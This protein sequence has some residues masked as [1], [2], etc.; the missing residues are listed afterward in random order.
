MKERRGRLRSEQEEIVALLKQRKFSGLLCSDAERITLKSEITIFHFPGH[1]NCLWGCN[2]RYAPDWPGFEQR[3]RPGEKCNA[4][5][6][7]LFCSCCCIFE[8]SLPYLIDR[9]AQIEAH[10][11][12][13]DESDFISTLKAEK[14]LID[15]LVIAWDDDA[16]IQRAFA[17]QQKNSPLFP[18]DLSLFEVIFDDSELAAP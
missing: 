3:V 16:A 14:A 5:P 1:E 11:A 2:N 4:S 13:H 18:S 10:M 6:N 9:Y 15:W 8:D 17:Y 7:C 12:E